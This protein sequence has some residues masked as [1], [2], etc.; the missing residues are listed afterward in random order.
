MRA[1]DVFFMRLALKEGRKGLGRTSPNPPVGAV[2]VKD[3]RVVGKGFHRRAGTPHA[4]INALKEAGEAACG[5]TIYVT[6]EPCNHY[7]RTPPC[8]KAILE[9]GI[10]RVVIGCRDPNPKARGGAEYLASKGLEVVT[11][12]LLREC[13]ELCR[14]FLKSVKTSLPWVLSK[15]AMSLDGRIAT[16]TGD[17]KWITGEHARRFGHR[18]RHLCDAILV[19]KGT[20]LADDPALTCRLKGGRNPIRIVLDTNLSIRPDFRLF[21]EEGRTIVWCGEGAPQAREEVFLKKGV[22]VWRL[23]LEGGR[24]S[25]REGL[26]RAVRA[27]ILSILVEGGARVHGSFFDAKLVDE[28]AFFYG[29]LIIGGEKAPSAVGGLGPGRLS[30]ALRLSDFSLKRL[31]DSFLVRGFITDPSTLQ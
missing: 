5:A 9:A 13:A 24:V 23:P 3:G 2:V 27:G 17:S 14:F 20:V 21:K 29:P 30:E 26:L 10:K 18:L 11:G 8:T 15:A 7:G 4:E 31:K 25:L 1:E 19:G 12:V 22:E 16:R 6:L 28:V